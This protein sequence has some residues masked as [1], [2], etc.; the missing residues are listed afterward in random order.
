MTKSLQQL[1]LSSYNANELIAS[2]SALFLTVENVELSPR[3][4]MLVKYAIKST[5]SSGT[6]HVTGEFLRKCIDSTEISS[7]SPMEDTYS[8]PFLDT[9]AFFG[10]PY[11]VFRGLA[12][13]DCH[14]L[15]LLLGSI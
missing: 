5:S 7:A 8:E 1:H 15:K 12:A 11:N 13:E 4:E 14:N 2:C 10:G 3:L 9:I 6:K